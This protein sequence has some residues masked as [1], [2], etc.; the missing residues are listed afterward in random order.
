M[1][2]AVKG[3]TSILENKSDKSQGVWGTASPIRKMTSSFLS[4]REQVGRRPIAERLVRALVIVEVEIVFQR[5]E[6]FQ[7]GG[8]VA[9]IDQLVFERAPQPFDENIV[10]RAP[11]AIHAD[12][13]AALLSGA[14]KSAEVNCEP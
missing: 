2:F 4:V 13:D 3:K 8:E 1:P 9:G 14:R 5:R 6:Q 10:E 11:A 12:R 7:A